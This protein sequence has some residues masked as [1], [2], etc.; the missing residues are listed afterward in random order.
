MRFDNNGN[1]IRSVYKTS[2]IH[3]NVIIDLGSN[4]DGISDKS[5]EI[6]YSMIQ[7]NNIKKFNAL[8]KNFEI[9]LN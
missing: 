3:D 2:Q 5:I 9:I 8:L 6:V 1:H 7:S 4:F